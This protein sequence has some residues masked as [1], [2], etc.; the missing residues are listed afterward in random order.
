MDNLGGCIDYCFS[1]NDQKNTACNTVYH[2][3]IMCKSSEIILIMLN[4]FFKKNGLFTFQETVVP[5]L[6][7]SE[8]VFSLKKSKCLKQII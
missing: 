7:G 6:W 1:G 3:V 8:T 2:T 4:G 5:C